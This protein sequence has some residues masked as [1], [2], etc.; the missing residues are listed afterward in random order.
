VK[1]LFDGSKELA[2]GQIGLPIIKG[3]LPLNQANGGKK[4]PIPQGYPGGMADRG[5]HEGE[6]TVYLTCG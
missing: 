1:T 6:I 3:Y 2:G 4:I 5:S